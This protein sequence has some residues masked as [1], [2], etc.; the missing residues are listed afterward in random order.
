MKGPSLLRH[1]EDNWETEVGA[2]FPGERVVVRGED[3]FDGFKSASWLEYL[4]FV[5][6]GK[7]DEQLAHIVGALW[8]F[9]GS[10]PDP[11]VWN[12]RVATLAATVKSTGALGVSA[13]VAVSEATL[14]GLK[15]IKGCSDFFI[16]TKS[17]LEKGESLEMILDDELHKHRSIYGYGRPIASTD[18]RISPTLELV[19]Q[20]GY[21]DGYYLKLV[22]KIESILKKKY[23]IQMNQ[24]ALYSAIMLDAGLSV[25]E[26]YYLSIFLFSAGMYAPFIEAHSKPSGAFFPLR[27]SR[28]NNKGPNKIRVWGD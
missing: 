11:R 17:C 8:V 14:Y 16:K 4:L 6:T 26:I 7:R 25:T 9:S 15:P 19:N 2:S 21:G 5:V 18:E 12:N 23:R 3:L 10:Y 1:Y 20:Y 24:A 28:I 27:V 13:G 22:L